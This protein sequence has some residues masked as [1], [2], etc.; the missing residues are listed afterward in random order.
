VEWK[1]R[2]LTVSGLAMGDTSHLGGH[3]YRVTGQEPL[4]KKPLAVRL[5]I[6]DD[7]IVRAMEDKGK[8]MREAIRAALIDRA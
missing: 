6:S 1:E 5:Y 4:A 3:Q 2:S 7:E 8:F